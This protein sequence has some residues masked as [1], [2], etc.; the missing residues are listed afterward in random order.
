MEPSSEPSNVWICPLCAGRGSLTN[1]N[2]SE[3]AWIKLVAAALQQV[4]AEAKPSY[5]PPPP[6]RLGIR[7]I[8]EYRS[9]LRRG[10]RDLAARAKDDPMTYNRFERSRLWV[11]TDPVETMAILREQPLLKPGLEGSGIQEGP[12]YGD[13]NRISSTMSYP[14]NDQGSSLTR[15]M[16]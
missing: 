2:F 16:V 14:N 7:P 9:A 10:Y 13:S 8:G 4:A 5:S 11:T 6:M 1:S 3:E 12:T 15:Q